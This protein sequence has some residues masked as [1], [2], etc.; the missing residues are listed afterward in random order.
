V[1][2]VATLVEVRRGLVDAADIAELRIGHD[3]PHGVLVG[4]WLRAEASRSSWPTPM[5]ISI[6]AVILAGAE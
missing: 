2:G 4:S 3:G 1:S 6:A 5:A